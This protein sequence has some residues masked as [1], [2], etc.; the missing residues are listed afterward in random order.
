MFIDK[1]GRF[2][3]PIHKMNNILYNLH[4]AIP[5]ERIKNAASYILDGLSQDKACILAGIDTSEFRTLMENDQAVR[6]YILKKEIEF[7]HKQLKEIALKKSDK[8]AQWILEKT[9]PEQY[10]SNKKA[11]TTTINI[12]SAIIK[13]IQNNENQTI[14]GRRVHQGQPEAIEAREQTNTAEYTVKEFLK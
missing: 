5:K 13:D 7:E 1:H 8:N 4:M 6:D 11:D 12:V 14:I 9:R 10:G 2:S 3:T